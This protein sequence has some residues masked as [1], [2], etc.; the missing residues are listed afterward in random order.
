ML[1]IKCSEDSDIL[2]ANDESTYRSIAYNSLSPQEKGSIIPDWE[3]A[4]VLQG[5]YHKK[6]DTD[7]FVIDSESSFSFYLKDSIVTLINGQNLVSV[8]FNT[9]DDSL[10]GPIVVIVDTNSEKAIGFLLRL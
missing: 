1:L 4:K 6:G 3:E 5:V 10:L 7:I 9:V 2:S 8:T